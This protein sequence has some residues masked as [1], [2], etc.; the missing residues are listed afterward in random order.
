MKE[1]LEALS[2]D[3]AVH[4]M[5]SAIFMMLKEIKDFIECETIIQPNVYMF[6]HARILN[7]YSELE[8][9]NIFLNDLNRRSNEVEKE[10]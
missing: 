7:L 4:E 2:G 10:C 6:I 1:A 5:M 3:N 9:I 8:H